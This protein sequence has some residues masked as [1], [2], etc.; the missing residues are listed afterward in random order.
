MR[1][2]LGHLINVAPRSLVLMLALDD[3]AHR[4]RGSDDRRAGDRRLQYRCADNTG[5]AKLV[6]YVRDDPGGIAQR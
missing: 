3:V 4:E 5:N 1:F 6:H 2:K